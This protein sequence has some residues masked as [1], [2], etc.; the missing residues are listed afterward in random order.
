VSTSLVIHE[1]GGVTVALGLRAGFTG[2]QLTALLDARGV[3]HDFAEAQGETRTAIVL[4]DIEAGQQSTITAP[5]LQATPD[6]LNHLHALLERHAPD[7]WGVVCGGTLPS[8]LPPDSHARLLRHAR[9]FGLITLLDASGEALRQGVAGRPDILKINRHELEALDAE[10]AGYTEPGS[11]A[12]WLHP[13]L[14]R[15]S[16]VGLVITLGEQGALAVTSAGDYWARPPRVPVANTA[17][18]GDALGAGLMLALSRGLDWPEALTL[19]TAAAASV[20]MNEGTAICKRNQVEAL[21][22]QAR[23]ERL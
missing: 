1:L 13:Q 23:I 7:A 12:A 4:I 8:G 22:P 14:D 2:Q 5:T 17:G 11:L 18:A 20:V 9:E 15:W 6:S 16:A 3:L 10:S 19:G 21:L